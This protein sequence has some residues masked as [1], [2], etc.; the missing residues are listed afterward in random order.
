M[1]FFTLS[2]LNRIHAFFHEWSSEPAT[3]GR[4]A[5]VLIAEP[6][7]VS[8]TPSPNIAPTDG[9]RSSRSSFSSSKQYHTNTSRR[10]SGRQ[11]IDITS[12]TLHSI[13]SLS[14]IA[15]SS[16]LDPPDYGNKG[17]DGIL[18]HH[19]VRRHDHASHIVSQVAEW[20]HNE[21]VKR[22]A[23]RVRRHGAHGAH[24]GL[25]HA[26]EATRNLVNQMRSDE[27]KHHRGGRRRKSSDLS[28]G[29]LA[30]E[31]LEEILSKSMTLDGDGAVT[32]TEDKKDSYFPRQKAKRQG[33]KRLLRKA[34]TIAS[35]DTEYQEPDIDVPSA[36]VVLDNSRTLGYSGG[37]A[38]SEFD[39]HSSKKR[40]VKEKEAWIQFK[41]EI[42]R[43]A[44]TLRL[45]GWRRTPLDR[46]SEIDVERLS[47]ALTN[48]VYVVSPPAN[49]AETP[50][51]AEESKN[52]FVSKKPPPYAFYPSCTKK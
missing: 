42:I 28:D 48:A 18:H 21:R 23:H 16:T 19:H 30:L 52:S 20:L 13:S 47:G 11:N 49:L 12:P 15:S 14:S 33:S 45:K 38:S 9:N 29:S 44:H 41:H 32:P 1:T 37:V 26:A 5:A 43:L 40:A 8:P 35:S 17:V 2:T 34:S 50:S 27:S 3:D 7:S 4:H 25:T 22:A 51:N 24:V 39:L 10:L 6:D 31:K 46:S 36:E